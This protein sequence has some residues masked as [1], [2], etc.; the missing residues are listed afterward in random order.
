MSEKEITDLI[1][2]YRVAWNARDFEKMASLFSEPVTY[3]VPGGNLHIPDKAALVLKLQQ[4]FANLEAEGF[5]HTEIGDV[6]VTICNEYA[7][8]AELKNLR[9]LK[10]D[11]S[12]IGAID[13]L[14]ICVLQEGHWRLS[15]G[16]AGQRGWNDKSV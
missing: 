1:E 7:A 15:V 5:D 10:A 8:L 9:R 16:M 14:Y 4:Q 13:A 12:E 2:T 11:G 3:I 6:V